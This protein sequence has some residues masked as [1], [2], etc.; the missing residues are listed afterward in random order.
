MS[1]VSFSVLINGRPR[2]KFKGCKGLRQ[3]DPLSPFLFTLVS[4]RSSRL[5]ERATEV[6]F[7]KGC[8]VGRDNVM[9]SHLQFADDTLFFVELEESSFRNLLLLVGLFGAVSGLK[10]NMTKSLLLGMGVDDVFVSSLAESVGCEVGAWPTT[11]L[12]LPLGGNPC[13][14]SFWEP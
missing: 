4:D 5:V 11:Y 2:S 3:G 12:G 8:K 6:G 14:R 13:S 7:V 10:I 1:S 9:I